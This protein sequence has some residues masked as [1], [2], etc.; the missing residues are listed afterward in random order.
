MIIKKKKIGPTILPVIIFVVAFLQYANTIRHEYAW[1]D[2]LVITGNDYTQKGIS[3]LTEI[4]TNR[5]TIPYKNVYR[6]VPQA[7]F[8]IEQELFKQN[9]HAGHFFNVLWY[10]LLCVTVYFF[11]RFLFP[12]SDLLFS[13]LASLIFTVHPLHTEVVANIKSRDEILA[14]FFGLSALWLLVKSLINGRWWLLLP[15]VACFALAI[16]SKENIITLLPVIIIAWWYKSDTIKLNRGIFAATII[17]AAGLGIGYWI[18]QSITAAQRG[19]SVQLDAT[20]LNNVFLWTTTPGSVVP[21]SIVNIGRYL[22]LFIYPHPLVH[23]YGYNQVPLSSWGSF[24]TWVVMGLLFLAVLYMIK[25][26]KQKTPAMFGILF[27]AITYSV[28]SNLFVLA[29]D[30]MADR[31]MFIP[32][33]GLAL[34]ATQL[35]TNVIS[36]IVEKFHFPGSKMILCTIVFTC[37]LSAYFIQTFLANRDWKN[38]YTLIYNRIKYMQH[39]AAAQATYG[40]MLNRESDEK[41]NAEERTILKIEAM[42][43]FTRSVEIFPDFYWSWISI[44]KIF[45]EQGEYDKAELA[46]LKAQQLE[47][48]SA[49]SYF[50]LGS[51]YYTRGGGYLAVTYLER[52]VLLEPESEQSYTMLGKAYLQTSSFANLEGLATAGIKK[53]PRNAEFYALMATCYYHKKQY[54]EASAHMRVALQLDPS[55]ITAQVLRSAP[56]DNPDKD[57]KSK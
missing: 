39:N 3:G 15:G 35:V 12:T 8:A 50:C 30:T 2:K 46:F 55:N 16:L 26:F 25:N 4:F 5:V 9:P 41:N 38:D 17:I 22:W 44:G 37:I 6:P 56:A 20:V 43:A 42:K 18:N 47:P 53:F 7:L 21:T 1:D 11:F 45:A 32:S 10:G 23:M 19:G 27:F 51:L 24:A 14:L 31:Y 49:D 29:P 48:V 36:I 52:A 57:V 28:Y 13:F 54:Q 34:I 40:L 33:L